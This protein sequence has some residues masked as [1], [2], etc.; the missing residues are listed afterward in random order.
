MFFVTSPKEV[1]LHKIQIQIMKHKVI[2]FLFL[3]SFTALFAQNDKKATDILNGV[4]K[5]YKS[6]KS[7][8]ANF[9]ILIEN[10]KENSKETQK[11]TLFTKGQYYKLLIAGQEVYSD[12]KTRWTYLK[13]ANEIQID[14][15]KIDE[16]AIT[17]SNIFTMYEKGWL[18]KFIEEKKVKNVTTQT[19]ELI[20]ADGKSKNIFKVRLAI[21]KS[22]KNIL[23]AKI[24]DKNGSFQTI[25]VEKLFPNSSNEDSIYIFN[26]DN[27]PGSD[28]VDLR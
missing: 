21:N 15:Q 4:S 19:I 20:P 5:K 22:E 7:L 23:S 17:P 11:G 27:Y 24:F 3:F 9:S 8:K 6:Y 10:P 28:I 25:T 26:K 1:L 2:L 16:N 18:S 12:G 14:N 13:D